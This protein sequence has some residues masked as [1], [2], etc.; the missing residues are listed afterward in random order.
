MLYRQTRFY[1]NC[2]K[3]IFDG[4][5]KYGIPPIKG[6]PYIDHDIKDFVDWN[7]ARSG[8]NPDG[9]AVHFFLDDYHFNC[10]WTNPERYIPIL[11]NYKYVFS[12]DFSPYC[13]FPKAVQV[14]NH[15]RKH[16]IAAYMQENGVNVIPTITWS[17]PPSYEFCFDGEPENS[18]VALS[19]VGCFKS[20]ELKG[21]F[22]EGYYEMV[23]RLHPTEIIFYGTVPDECKGNI[24]R[25]QPF[26][27]KFSGMNKATCEISGVTRN[28]QVAEINFEQINLFE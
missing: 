14:F 12:P 17:F 7:Y 19:S 4:V 15:Y 5:G 2:E 13:D 10:L 27:T 6:T 23:D 8:K 25:V 3:R 21:M 20:E 9:K 1:E 28:T 11:Q 16:W 22:I 26:Q 18:V 24:I